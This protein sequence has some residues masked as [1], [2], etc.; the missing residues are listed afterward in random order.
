M[1]KK[2]FISVSVGFLR[3]LWRSRCS[4]C[5]CGRRRG[6]RRRLRR[7]RSS[8]IRGVRTPTRPLEATPAAW[9]CASSTRCTTAFPASRT[10]ST[11]TASTSSPPASPASPARR[12]SSPQGRW[13]NSTCSMVVWWQQLICKFFIDLMGS[14]LLLFF[15]YITIKAKD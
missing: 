11:R 8:T 10:C 2:C 9:S 4:C 7:T 13:T 5:C 6:R 1:C 15:R 12:P 3:R 14:F